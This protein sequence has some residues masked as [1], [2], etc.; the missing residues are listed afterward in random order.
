M[1]VDQYSEV[2]L[3][4]C[5]FQSSEVLGV[6]VLERFIVQLDDDDEDGS[7]YSFIIG[8]TFSYTFNCML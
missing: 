7:Y 6:F 8:K 3:L 1:C 5:F 2:A 4:N